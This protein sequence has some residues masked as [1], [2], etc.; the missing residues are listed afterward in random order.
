MNKIEANAFVLFGGTGDLTKRK[1]IPAIYNLYID[2]LLPENFFVASVGRREKTEDEYKKELEDAI[3]K[4]SRNSFEQK[5]WDKVSS[6]IYYYKLDFAVED[7]Y[8]DFDS[9]LKSLES[10]HETQGNRLFYLAVGPE[11][12]ATIVENLHKNSMTKQS[13]GKKSV[14]IEKPFGKDLESAIRLNE[15]ITKV[16]DEEN[17]FRIDHYLGKE[18]LQNIMV[19]RFANAVFEPIWNSSHIDHVQITS[20]EQMG[21]GDRAGYYE[22]AGALKDMV[23]NHLLQFLSLIAMEPPKK[24]STESIRDAKVKVLKDLQIY[25]NEQVYENVVRGQYGADNEAN[26]KAYRDEDRT[27]DNSETET[28]VALKLNV[29][30]K[31]WKGVPFYIRTGKRLKY[32]GVQAVIE[33]KPNYPSNYNEYS[34]NIE[35]NQLIIRIQPQEGVNFRFN[36]KKPGEG[37]DILPVNMDFCQNC[38]IGYNSQE[39]YERLL[40]DAMKGDKTLFTRWDEVMYSWKFVDA[41]SNAWRK[42][43][44]DFPNYNP[45][46]FGPD[47]ANHLM[48]RDKREWVNEL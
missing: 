3:K 27:D 35:P 9:Y 6:R 45:H 24:I 14:I 10:I 37:N 23:Q 16:F 28:F 41:I 25:S 11:H 42:E 22:K 18:M 12:F 33:F 29:D 48:E 13:T 43:K 30:N 44:P 7:G 20:S 1:L 47:A 31:R 26:I 46:S 4:Y 21:V 32:K 8:R 38:E 36:A 34:G 2:N 19:I 5:K 17:I 39:A 15:E 40:L